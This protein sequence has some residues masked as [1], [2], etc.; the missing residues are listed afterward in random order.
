MVE[1]GVRGADPGVGSGGQFGGGLGSLGVQ[2]V[3]GVPPLLPALVGGF[4]LGGGVGERLG[5]LSGTQ[6]CL[7]LGTVVGD[8]LSVGATGRPELIM[9]GSELVGDNCRAGGGGLVGLVDDG[10]ETFVG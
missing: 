2:V 9:N 6:R 3:G 8:G 5:G 10:F 7:G 4:E 1:V